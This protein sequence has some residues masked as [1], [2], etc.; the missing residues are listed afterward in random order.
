MKRFDLMFA[1]LGNGVTV[2]DRARMEHGDYKTVAHIDPCGAVKLYDDALP[3]EALEK[4]NRQA[5]ME[6]DDFKHG[7]E[8]LSRERALDCVYDRMT[9]AQQ[10]ARRD[11]WRMSREALYALYVETVCENERRK[12]PA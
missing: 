12:M 10:L 5:A 7:F 8:R 11:V 4:I 3:P 2:C 1:C 6:R 9:V